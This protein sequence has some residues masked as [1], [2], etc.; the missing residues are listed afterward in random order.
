MRERKLLQIYRTL[1]EAFGPQEWWPARTR[2]E[3]VLGAILTQNTA[4]RNVERVIGEL[5]AR[6]LV[7]AGA[8]DGI[9]KDE[10]ARLIRPAG[11]FN[12]KAK[13]IKAFLDYFRRYG[14]S[15]EKMSCESK[16]KLREELLSVWGV[17]PETADAILLYALDKP[18]FVVDAYTRRAF[19][20]MGRVDGKIGYEEL[21]AFFES[22]ADWDRAE[23]SRLE[24]F[25]E[26]HALI[27]EL[28]KRFCKPDPDCGTCP[29]RG[30]CDSRDSFE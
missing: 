30:F 18:V 2:F 24:T 23:D 21:R 9:D 4:W 14:F 20:R 22:E 29:V 13:K 7:D 8:L 27:D 17:G 15:L 10:L 11:Y 1:M 16:E 19:S 3:V 5:E 26:F 12:Q 6:G 28:A 25:R